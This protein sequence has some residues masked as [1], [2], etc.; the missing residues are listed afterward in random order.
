MKDNLEPTKNAGSTL[1]EQERA[2]LQPA[3][4]KIDAG[5]RELEAAYAALRRPAP[6][7]DPDSGICGLNCGCSSFSGDGPRCDRPFCKHARHV[8]YT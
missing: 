5:Y 7:K 2:T 4:E 8:H 1:T 3:F 6:P